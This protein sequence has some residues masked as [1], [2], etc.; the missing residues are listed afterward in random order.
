MTS[1]SGFYPCLNLHLL[2]ACTNDTFITNQHFNLDQSLFLKYNAKTLWL[3][4]DSLSSHSPRVAK[5]LLFASSASKRTKPCT[6]WYTFF[7]LHIWYKYT[8]VRHLLFFTI[9]YIYSILCEYLN[10]PIQTPRGFNKS[11]HPFIFY[12]TR[13]SH[14]FLFK[15][16]QNQFIVHIFL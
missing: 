3:W 1:L 12:G 4:T 8:H 5:P 11:Q 13:K 9:I 14:T 2:K 16:N 15:Q 7:W 6:V 10:E